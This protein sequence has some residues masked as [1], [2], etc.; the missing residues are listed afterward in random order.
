ML[1]ELSLIDS[2]P[3]TFEHGAY[4]KM[5]DNVPSTQEALKRG[6]PEQ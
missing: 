6:Q 4:G 3:R 1:L 2:G 5:R